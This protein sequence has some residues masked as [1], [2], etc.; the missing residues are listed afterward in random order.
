MVTIVGVRKVSGCGTSNTDTKIIENNEDKNSLKTHLIR[1]W[2]VVY[3]SGLEMSIY[4]E[5]RVI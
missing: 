4:T 3:D 2:A 1:F 5:I